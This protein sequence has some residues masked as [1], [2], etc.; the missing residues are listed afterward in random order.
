V[1][2]VVKIGDT[3]FLYYIGADGNRSTDGGPRNR[4]LGVATSNDGINF[5]KYSG[6]PILTYQPHNNQEEGIFSGYAVY[7]GGRVYLV[8][9]A[10]RAPNSTSESVDGHFRL[11]ESA[12]G[13]HF[14]DKGMIL[15]PRDSSVWGYGDEIFPVGMYRYSGSWHVYY[16]A[17]GK[18]P[19]SWSLGV[20]SGPSLSSLTATRSASGIVPTYG[21][22]PILI[23]ENKIA[24]FILKVEDGGNDPIEVRTASANEPHK[25]GD[26]VETYRFGDVR[27]I[28]VFLDEDI[29][30][31]FLYYLTDSSPNI[32]KVKTAPAKGGG[33]STGSGTGHTPDDS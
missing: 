7:E 20:A 28:G 10:M 25:L 15:S 3:Y 6:N 1:L 18:G 14:T 12:D 13:L 26:P 29:D 19:P 22:K 16:T 21:G 23:G 11:A 17:K 31:W 5:T 24:N 9:G 32:I 30:K 33:S 8:Y 2:S 4:K 27:V